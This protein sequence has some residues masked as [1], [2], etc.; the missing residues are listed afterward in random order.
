[1]H[2]VTS[3]FNQQGYARPLANCWRF[4]DALRGAT[5]HTIEL[6]FT[7]DF[8]IPDAVHVRGG[9]EHVMWQK[10]R[11]LNLLVESLPDDVSE[12]AWIDADLLLLNQDWARHAMIGLDQAAVVQLFE[13]IHFTNSDGHVIRSNDSFVRLLG[14]GKGGQAS[15]GG[16]WAARRDVF[17]I[18]DHAICGGGDKLLVEA[19]VGNWAALA[20]RLSPTWANQWIN[21]C[22]RQHRLIDGRLGYIHGDAVHLWHGSRHKRR[23]DERWHKLRELQFDP[24]RDIAIDS[25]GL[26]KWASDKPELHAFVADYF[27][28]RNEDGQ[29]HPHNGPRGADPAAPRIPGPADAS[30]AATRARAAATAPA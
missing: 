8:Q 25:N 14:T 21:S 9:P 28:E 3:H 16:A 24:L 7:G 10:E 17:P 12:V 23:Y 6:S 22:Q 1:V 11:L 30:G 20:D 4:R 29:S 19:W 13:H 26:W 5:L 27:A 2:V 15:P 18:Y